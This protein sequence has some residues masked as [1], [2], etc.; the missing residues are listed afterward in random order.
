M[1]LKKKIWQYTTNGEH[2]ETWESLYKIKI[3][4]VLN[5][6]NICN[7]CN[8]R[9]K[10]AYGYVWSFAEL[11]PEGVAENLTKRIGQAKKQESKPT[12]NTKMSPYLKYVKYLYWQWRDYNEEAAFLEYVCGKILGELP[13]QFGFIFN[14]GRGFTMYNARNLLYKCIEPEV[15]R[16]RKYLENVEMS[17]A[18]ATFKMA[19]WRGVVDA[20]MRTVCEEWKYALPTS[21]VGHKN[22]IPLVA[23]DPETLQPFAVF[24]SRQEAIGVV[25]NTSIPN[26]EK[27]GSTVS[28]AKWMKHA[29]FLAGKPLVQEQRPQDKSLENNPFVYGIKSLI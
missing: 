5:I 8:G 10:T 19:D 14:I 18:A 20:V 4:T 23:L 2:V 11:T 6:A 7:C 24:Q 13:R 27:F 16:F 9:Q 1:R 21:N 17:V 12:K 26:A 3:E 29:D 15:K 22:N 25:C 28:G